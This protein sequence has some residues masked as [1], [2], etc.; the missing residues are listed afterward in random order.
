MS[1]RIGRT[2]FEALAPARPGS[3]RTNHRSIHCS[4]DSKSLKVTRKADGSVDAHCFRCGAKGWIPPA[5]YYRPLDKQEEQE[6]QEIDG[7]TLPADARARFPSVALEWLGKAGILPDRAKQLGMLWSEE[8]QTLYI[9]VTQ[10]TSAFGQK[11]TGFVLR[12]FQP[13]SYLTLTHASASFWGFVRGPSVDPD[14]HG[15]IVLVEDM[16]SGHRVAE[17]A[18]CLVLCGTELKPQ[19]LAFLARERYNR[20]V[21]FLDGDNSIVKGKARKIARSL[22]WMQVGVVETGTD[23]KRYSKQEIDNLIFGNTLS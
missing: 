2:E 20:A 19:A 18:D 17:V 12:G 10:D 7:Y 14:R 11:L 4:G 9:P 23:P 6:D 5:G 22:S 8:K 15:T 13:K 16:L 21:V 3:I 1:G